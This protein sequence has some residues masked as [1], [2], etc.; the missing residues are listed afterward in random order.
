M[1]CYSVTKFGFIDID[2]LLADIQQEMTGTSLNNSTAYFRSVYN[3]DTSGP[4][5]YGAA[6]KSNGGSPAKAVYILKTTANVDPLA[7][8]TTVGLYTSMTDPGWRL[9]FH[10]I[11]D[12]RLAVH[13]ATALQ[14]DNNGNIAQLGSRLANGNVQLRDPVGNIGSDWFAANVVA[15]ATLITANT[16]TANVTT[17]AITGNVPPATAEFNKIWLNRVSSKGSE[18]A[19]PMSYQLTMTNRG[20]FLA[21]WEGSQ[22]E[23]PQ[24]TFDTNVLNPDGTMGNSPLRWFV[25]QRSVDRVTGHVR[26]GAKLREDSNPVAE[27]SRCPV[28]CVSGTSSPQQFQKFV[29]REVDVL[30]PSLKRP[31]AYDTED[32][33]SLLNPWPQQSLT[34]SGEFVV[35][36]LNNLSTP[37]FRYADEMDMLGTVGAEVI[38]AGTS[39]LVNVYGEPYKREYTALYATERFGTGMRLMV[40]TKMGYDPDATDNQNQ[41]QNIQV[42]D[43]HVNYP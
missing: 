23:V 11:D 17:S 5:S 29:V 1:A 16:T 19:Y 43:S 41:L 34:E 15:T 9:C 37:R 32:S 2:S 26:G 28:F 39:V 7:N 6:V 24:R 42:E 12:Y 14:L 13:A 20:I 21:V 36:F 40:L 31:A 38:G 27:L 18:A 35:T 25:I 30:T 3:S 4:P 33:P 22:E 10:Q 8:A